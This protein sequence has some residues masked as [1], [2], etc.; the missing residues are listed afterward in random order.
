MGMADILLLAMAWLLA[1][2]VVARFL[3]GACA[4]GETS[5][6]RL[7]EWRF[8][9][10]SAA[11][12]DDELYIGLVLERVTTRPTSCFPVLPGDASE[13]GGAASRAILS[14]KL[15]PRGDGDCAVVPATTPVP[16]V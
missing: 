7:Q 3:G 2:F 15:A 9:D 11:T 16:V 4:M 8:I 14:S 1:S 12:A 5:A 6:E 10:E 13:R